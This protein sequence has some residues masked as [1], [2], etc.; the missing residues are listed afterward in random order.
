MNVHNPEASAGLRTFPT[1]FGQSDTHAKILSDGRPNP[2]S[3][4]GTPYGTI[5]GMTIEAMLARPQRVPKDKAQWFLPSTYADHD[6]RSS[7]AQRGGG[8][9]WFLPIDI[10]DNALSLEDVIYALN[11]AVPGAKQLVYS[12]RSATTAA[13]RWRALV[14]LAAALSGADYLDTQ[15][16]FFELLEEA[17]NGVLIPCAAFLRPAQLVYLPNAGEHY[18]HHIQRGQRVDLT[19]HPITSRRELRRAE[20]GEIEREAREARERSARYRAANAGANDAR[21]VDHFNERHTIEQLLD[22][23]RY[24]HRGG[25]DWR[26][27]MQTSRSFLTRNYGDFWIS[28][29]ASDAG[30]EIGNALDSGYRIGDAFDLFVHFEHGGN[31]KEAVT[32]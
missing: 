31:F 25:D 21:P 1:G 24:T 17:S 13:L 12:S 26:S 4:A 2:S 29:S 8:Q 10:D 28:L 27:P 9:F 22:R 15:A 20:R 6:A 14:P 11:V 18:E 3:L 23:Y 19:D 32:A 7:K 30:A 16:A 5:D